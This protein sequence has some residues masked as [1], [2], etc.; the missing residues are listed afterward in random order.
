MKNTLLLSKTF[1]GIFS[2]SVKDNISL[3]IDLIS[4]LHIVHLVKSF[5]IE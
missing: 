1:L 4:A 2:L 5:V 3:L